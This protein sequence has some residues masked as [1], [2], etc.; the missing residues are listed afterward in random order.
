MDSLYIPGL[1]ERKGYSGAPFNHGNW[2]DIPDDLDGLYKRTIKHFV[3]NKKDKYIP[4]EVVIKVLNESSLNITDKDK[5]KCIDIL[6]NKHKND[7]EIP[8]TETKLIEYNNVVNDFISCK[9]LNAILAIL[10]EDLKGYHVPCRNYTNPT[11]NPNI[12]VH[13]KILSLAQKDEYQ[14]PENFMAL[15]NYYLS[16]NIYGGKS[17]STKVSFTKDGKTHTR[18]V[19]ANKR[20]TKCVTYKGTEIPVSKL[21]R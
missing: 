4:K 20:G 2:D 9:D 8:E 5:F 14:Y 11:R 12:M 19:H 17:A 3:D 16:D 7:M 10:F 6:R 1:P 21:K 13:N 18:V 15:I